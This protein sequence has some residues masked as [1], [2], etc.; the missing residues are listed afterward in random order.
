MVRAYVDPR[1]GVICMSDDEMSHTACIM[2]TAYKPFHP[3][4]RGSHQTYFCPLLRAD[5]LT[6]AA[7]VEAYQ[8]LNMSTC[9]HPLGL[10]YIVSRHLSPVLT[11]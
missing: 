2:C 4:G 5:S 1:A 9:C 11:E 6:E 8:P 10:I 7:A 3:T